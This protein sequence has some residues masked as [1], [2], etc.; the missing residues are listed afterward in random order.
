MLKMANSRAGVTP[1]RRKLWLAAAALLSLTLPGAKSE[2][3]HRVSEVIRTPGLVAFW[4]FVK[5]D[6]A[7]GRFDAH[8]SKNET[9]DFRLDASNYVRDY[10]NEGREAG[11]ADIPLLG[12]G[13]FGQAIE[14]RNEKE[15]DFRPCLVIPRSRLAGSGL[16]VKGPGRSV[17]MVAWVARRAGNHAIAGIWHEGTDLKGEAGLAQRVERGQRQYALFAGL[18]ANEGASAVHVSDNGAKSFGDK[19]ARNLAVTPEKLKTAAT[20]AEADKAWSVMGFVFDNARDTV[21]AYLDGEA[22]EYWIDEPQK[23]GFFKWPAKGWLQAGLRMTPGMQEGEEP[24]FPADQFYRPP[25]TRLRT[26]EVVERSADRRVELRTYEFTKVR[27]TVEKVAGQWAETR[28]ELAALKAN[29]F[30]FGHDLWTPDEGTGG[31]F[32]IG[33][34]I[35][36]SRSVGFAGWIGGVAVFGRALTAK[37]MRRLAKIGVSGGEPATLPDP[38]GSA[39]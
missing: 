32:T 25:E 30:W 3:E 15:A 18:G 26:R 7:G 28:R 38:S 33:R 16:D 39:K 17:S 21:T 13:P 29:P 27:V 14:I 20:E 37:E 8:K 31:P 36:S 23:H 9:H 35:H 34:V 22:N 4:D 10:W 6:A 12:R 24:D 5:R 2:R 1:A 11:Y 19:Y